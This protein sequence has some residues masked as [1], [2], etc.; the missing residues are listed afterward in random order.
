MKPATLGVMA[1]CLLTLSGPAFAQIP[2]REGNW[3]ITMQVEM[4]GMSMK[5]PDIKDTRCITKDMLK[6][7][8]LTV[9]SASPDKNNDCVVSEY[10]ATGN[11]ATWKVTCSVP[12]PLSG[13][14]EVTYA[15]DTYSGSMTMATGAGELKLQYKGKR[16][17]DCGTPPA[18]R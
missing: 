12:V 1:L 2:V 15:G 18:V 5:M 11:H 8:A 3:E 9:P 10:K 17:G 7:P 16:L 13:S 4:A 6:D 14:G